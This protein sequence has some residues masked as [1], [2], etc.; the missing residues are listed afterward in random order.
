[1]SSRIQKIFQNKIRTY[2]FENRY[3]HVN[4]KLDIDPLNML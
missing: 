1:M 2:A 3:N 4:I